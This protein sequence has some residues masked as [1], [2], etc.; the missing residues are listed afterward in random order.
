MISSGAGIPTLCSLKA[1]TGTGEGFWIEQQQLRRHTR[2]CVNYQKAR[3]G[4]STDV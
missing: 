3:R 1:I 2:D 4:Q